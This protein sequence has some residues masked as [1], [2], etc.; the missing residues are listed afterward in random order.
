M[1]RRRLWFDIL[2]PPT[3][4][5]LYGNR[6]MEPALWLTQT[7]MKADGLMDPHWTWMQ[8]TIGWVSRGWIA[9]GQVPDISVSNIKID[10][11]YSFRD[12]CT[13]TDRL[14]TLTSTLLPYPPKP[15]TFRTFPDPRLPGVHFKFVASSC[16]VG[17]RSGRTQRFGLIHVDS[18]LTS[19]TAHWP[20]AHASKALGSLSSN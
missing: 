20:Q 7:R 16:L 5:V 10:M 8:R 4:S 18:Y 3:D 15:I 14:A 9:C 11:E 6:W 12:A 19:H 17:V 2:R 13:F 1:M